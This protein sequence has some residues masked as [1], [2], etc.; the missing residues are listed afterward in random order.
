MTSN[1]ILLINLGYY[2]YYAI[3]PQ[4]VRVNH[5]LFCKLGTESHNSIG[6]NFVIRVCVKV[7]IIFLRADHDKLIVTSDGYYFNLTLL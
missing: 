3:V 7:R 1:K 2:W 4:I 5:L 6:T